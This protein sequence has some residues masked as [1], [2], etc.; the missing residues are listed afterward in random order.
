M[1][2]NLI[3]VQGS[4]VPLPKFQMASRLKLLISSGSKEKEPRYTWLSEAKASHPQRMWAEGPEVRLEPVSVYYQDLT[5]LSNAGCPTIILSS[6]TMPRDSQRL[7]SSN[8]LLNR[9]VSC[10]LV[11]GFVSLYLSMS[12]D[13]IQPQSMLGG[14]REDLDSVRTKT[15]SKFS[16]FPL[17]GLPK[18]WEVRASP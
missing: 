1:P 2:H 15:K 4:P 11:D 8:K 16:E 5:T 3:S 10:E 13:P 17:S 14:E 6:Y 9:T 18:F 12:R 7:L